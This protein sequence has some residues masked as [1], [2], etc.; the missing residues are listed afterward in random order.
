MKKSRFTESRK[1]LSYRSDLDGSR[2]LRD[3]DGTMNVIETER[4]IIRHFEASDLSPMS[5]VLGDPEVMTFADGVKSDDWIRK[6]LKEC[7]EKLNPEI[8]ASPWAID[9]KQG[10]SVIGYCGL[11]YFPD[12]C[13]RPEIEIGYRLAR[14]YW[15]RGYATEAVCAVRD[16][17]FTVLDINRLIAMIDPGNAGSINVAEK[18]GFSYENDVMLE[19]YTH[20]DRVY[21]RNRSDNER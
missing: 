21:V 16:Y 9:L 13:G 14:R 5:A 3:R 11:S 4:L 10:V 6:W 12:I 19:G 17:A 20:S 15:G 2:L 7:I 18:A 8:G 1:A